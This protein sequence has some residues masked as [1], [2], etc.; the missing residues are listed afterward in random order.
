MPLVNPK[1]LTTRF[2]CAE[3]QRLANVR[4]VF[5]EDFCDD[6]VEQ[7]QATCRCYDGSGGLVSDGWEYP[8]YSPVNGG[9]AATP[10]HPDNPATSPSQP[11][12]DESPTD[13]GT[14]STVRMGTSVA[15]AGLLIVMI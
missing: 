10:G 9:A 6:I 2:P 11:T 13:G 15:M 5:P 7:S 14:S 1:Q 3:L 8:T 12:T 4:Y